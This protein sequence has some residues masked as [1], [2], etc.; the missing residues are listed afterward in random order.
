MDKV[1]VFND[2]NG[3]GFADVG[4]TITY[5]FT[6]TNT[7][8]VTVSNITVADPLVAVPGAI[9]SLAPGAVDTTTF[10]AV[11][12]L[13]Q[14]DLDAGSVENQAT[15]Q[16]TFPSGET[17]RQS[18]ND[19]ATAAV[20]DATVLSFTASLGEAPPALAFTG[21]TSAATA[22]LATLIIVL[23]AAFMAMSRRESDFVFVDDEL[24]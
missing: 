20:A 2:E 11:Y 7:G 12:T 3:D 14:A 23:G 4:E 10:S 5:T 6:V 21:R 13:T 19:P 17:I 18:S 16:A 8:N 9:L 24:R 22:A 1:G 15:A